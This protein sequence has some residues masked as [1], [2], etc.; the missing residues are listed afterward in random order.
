MELVDVG[1]SSLEIVLLQRG[2]DLLNEICDL[3]R[4]LRGLNS[5]RHDMGS[6]LALRPKQFES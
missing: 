4:V 3:V 1:A 2:L 6:G 5:R